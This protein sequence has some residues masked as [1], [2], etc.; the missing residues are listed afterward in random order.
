MNASGSTPNRYVETFW[1]NWILLAAFLIA[2]AALMANAAPNF[3]YDVQLE[4]MPILELVFG[5]CLFVLI[6]TVLLPRMIVRSLHQSVNALLAFMIVAGVFMRVLSFGTPS[7]LEDDYNRYLWD[8][9]VVAAGENPY[10]YSPDEV[11]AAGN[12]AGSL[13]QLKQQAGETFERINYPEFSTVYPPFAQAA[14]VLANWISPFSLDAWRAVLLLFEIA[15]LGLIVQILKALGKSP[16]WSAFYWW[17]PLVI[18]EVSNSAHMEPVLLLP[19]LAAAYLVVLRREIGSGL[20]LAIGAGVKVWP[21]MLAPALFR[22]MLDRPLKMFFSGVL[23]A[24]VLSVMVWPIL[25]A[26]IK[27]HSGFVAFARLWNASSAAYIVSDWVAGFLAG[28][29]GLFSVGQSELARTFLTLILLM[30]IGL[31]CLK[32]ADDRETVLKRMFFIIV[33]IYLLSPSQ[34]PW[35]FIWIA[36][37]LCFFPVR[38]LMIAGVTIPLHYSYFYLA[39]HELEAVYQ[40]GVVWIIWLPVWAICLLDLVFSD[41]NLPVGR[42]GADAAE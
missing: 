38:G 1:S 17:H 27:E 41:R 42:A 23:I 19:V 32:R 15:C 3:G 4:Q 20:M 25:A 8:G 26:G 2:G 33:A 18:K 9:A 24:A 28:G 10:R 31:I 36:P 35:Y 13:Q 12:P 5:Y 29:Y 39:A 16:L 14:F 34:T 40:W 7:I 6:F 22:Q 30:T 11:A 37:F 21:L